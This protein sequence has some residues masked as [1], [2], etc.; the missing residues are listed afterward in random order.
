[1]NTQGITKKNRKENTCEQQTQTTKN[2]VTIQQPEW[3]QEK[4]KK[5]IKEDKKKGVEINI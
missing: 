4:K 3:K 1:M 2:K 5:N